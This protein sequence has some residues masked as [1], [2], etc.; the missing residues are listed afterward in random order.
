MLALLSNEVD[1][2]RLEANIVANVFKSGSRISP[3]LFLN[4]EPV[5]VLLV[6]KV[7]AISAR[8]QYFLDSQAFQHLV[9]AYSNN[10]NYLIPGVC[11]FGIHKPVVVNCFWFKLGNFRFER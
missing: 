2:L 9:F 6:W 5:H 8:H 1:M 11:A 4:L 3:S 10:P 7:L